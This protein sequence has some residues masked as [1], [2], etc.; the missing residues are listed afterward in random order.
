MAEGFREY[1]MSRDSRNWGQ[2]IIDF[3][4]DLYAKVTNWKTLQPSLTAYYRAINGGRYVK[5]VLGT[6]GI[7]RLNDATVIW[8]HPGTGKT[9]LY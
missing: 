1:V 5:D 6:T 2:K 8:A 7:D 4:K 9:W 3:F